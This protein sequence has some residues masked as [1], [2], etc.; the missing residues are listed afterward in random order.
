MEIA[1]SKEL[2]NKA[3]TE[4][5][6]FKKIVYLSLNCLLRGDTD[7]TESKIVH[8]DVTVTQRCPVSI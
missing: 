5:I 8:R 1:E 3:K 2:G 6:R 4:K 7:A